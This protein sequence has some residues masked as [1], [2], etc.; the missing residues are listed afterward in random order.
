MKINKK[1]HALIFL[2]CILLI[3]VFFSWEMK[4]EVQEVGK[5]M[6]YMETYLLHQGK[7]VQ[8]QT[9]TT[10][11]TIEQKMEEII[12]YM[13]QDNEL[14]DPLLDYAT[15]LN[16]V[17]VKDRQLIYDF[18]VLSYPKQHEIRVW[19]ALVFAGTQFQEIDQI[20]LSVKGK[21][22][23]RMPLS[24]LDIHCGDRSFGI[25]HLKTNQIYLH[26]GES[27]LVYYEMKVGD[28]TYPVLQS[29]QMSDLD[30]YNEFLYRILSSCES[31]S[32]LIQPLAKYKII[33]KRECQLEKDVLHLYLNNQVMD[34][35]GEINKEIIHYFKLN[36]AQFDKIHYLSIHVNGKVIGVQGKNKIS[37][38]NK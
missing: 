28:Q 6:E 7:L 15:Q 13:K 35:N 30:D 31:S 38:G 17:I 34:K 24:Q 18:D 21:R 10:K 4:E 5:Q 12:S 22:V 16:Q 33:P 3:G 20:G 8:I 37:L 11:E 19:E 9:E 27:R 23:D 25:N 32:S 29:V 1:K 26:Q 36:F 14:F 2:L